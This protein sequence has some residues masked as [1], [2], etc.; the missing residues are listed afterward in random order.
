VADE[1]PTR[2]ADAPIFSTSLASLLDASR[3]VLIQILG[4]IQPCL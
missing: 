1:P 3:F 4:M 2:I